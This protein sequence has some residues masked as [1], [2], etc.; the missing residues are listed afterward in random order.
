MDRRDKLLD[1]RK[2]DTG[3]DKEENSTGLTLCNP[4]E[5]PEA[6]QE[7]LRAPSPKREL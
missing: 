2:E 4:Q 1:G 7:T 5:Y 6:N 3:R